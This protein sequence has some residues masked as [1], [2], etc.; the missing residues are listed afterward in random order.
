MAAAAP[1]KPLLLVAEE[2]GQ[3]KGHLPQEKTALHEKLNKEN[4]ELHSERALEKERL[5]KEL[6]TESEQLRRERAEEKRHLHEEHVPKMAAAAPG[7]PLLLLAEEPQEKTA[8]HEKLNKENR[9][10]HSE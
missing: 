2:P 7:K 1:G 8:L 9:E 5:A 3:E 10:L 6:Q 4:R